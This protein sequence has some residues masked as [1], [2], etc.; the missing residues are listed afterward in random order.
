MCPSVF[1]KEATTGT[2]ANGEG[3]CSWWGKHGQGRWNDSAGIGW[4]ECVTC[5]HN[6]GG[7]WI[8]YSLPSS[9]Q[10]AGRRRSPVLSCFAPWKEKKKKESVH[11]QLSRK[12]NS[13]SKA[14][15]WGCCS[16]AGSPLCCVALLLQGSFQCLEPDGEQRT[17]RGL[18]TAMYCS[19]RSS[20]MHTHSLPVLLCLSDNLSF[21][22]SISRPLLPVLVSFA[23]PSPSSP[24]SHCFCL[25]NANVSAH[26]LKADCSPRV[27]SGLSFPSFTPSCSPLTGQSCKD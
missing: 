16:S 2:K 25:F 15:L 17:Q 13:G 11:Y 26:T 3:R 5:L 1:A 7:A 20:A 21:T 4:S 10:C 27:R 9:W 12:H 22:R 18:G 8:D 19:A 14:S 6:P 24:S 23:L